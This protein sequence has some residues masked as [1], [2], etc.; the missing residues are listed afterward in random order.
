[1]SRNQRY[2]AQQKA[3]AEADALRTQV[4]AQADEVARLG[5]IVAS[6]L[7]VRCGGELEATNLR[8][9]IAEQASQIAQLRSLL[10]TG[11]AAQTG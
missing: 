11:G 8:A 2:E 5:R 7:C 1:V 9:R 6:H 4:Q 10:A 3:R